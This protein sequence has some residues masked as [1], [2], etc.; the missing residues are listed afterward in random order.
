M[1]TPLFTNDV[2]YVG[3]ILL[4][5]RTRQGIT[6]SFI[7]SMQNSNDGIALFDCEMSLD[8]CFKDLVPSPDITEIL[9]SPQAFR[10]F[11]PSLII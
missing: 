9:R 3:T 11:D 4:K 2:V 7:V 10:E 1:V 5:A 6:S 8:C